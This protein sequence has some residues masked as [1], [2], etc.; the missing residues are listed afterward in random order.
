M[1]ESSVNLFLT[2]IQVCARVSLLAKLL[3]FPRTFRKE[4]ISVVYSLALLTKNLSWRVRENYFLV[5]ENSGKLFNLVSG[6]PVV[7]CFE[8]W[9]KSLS[10]AITIKATVVP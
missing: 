10:T 2:N 9:M 3:S 7:V 1:Q 8:V 6:N 5:S 4:L